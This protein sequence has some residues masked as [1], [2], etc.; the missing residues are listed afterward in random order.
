MNKNLIKT[1]IFL[2]AVTFVT[3][4]SC[5]KK[6][7]TDTENGTLKEDI[8]NVSDIKVENGMLVLKNNDAYDNLLDTWS[9]LSFDNIL[10]KE[11]DLGFKSMYSEYQNNDN[12]KNLPCEDPF[13][14][15]ILNPDAKIKIGDYVFTLDFKYKFVKAENTKNKDLETFS[16]DEDVIPILFNGEVT[17]KSQYCSSSSITKYIKNSYKCRIKYYKAGIYNSLYT[18]LNGS[19]SYKNKIISNEN[20]TWENKKE[21][22]SGT[23]NISNNGGTLYYSIYKKTRRLTAYYANLYFSVDY[24]GSLDETLSCH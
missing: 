12:L 3:L 4:Q 6:A 13:L 23:I 8:E 11:K 2:I 7:L 17:E 19:D 18:Q 1:V 5:E 9:N 10:A 24:A 22:Y 20:V 16:F 15:L 21:S 14:A